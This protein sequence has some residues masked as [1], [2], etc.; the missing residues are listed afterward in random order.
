MIVSILWELNLVVN[1]AGARAALEQRVKGLQL[2]SVILLHHGWSKGGLRARS[3]SPWPL[4]NRHL[5]GDQARA[6]IRGRALGLNLTLTSAIMSC[7]V[8][9]LLGFFV[10][11]EGVGGSILGHSG[12]KYSQSST[13]LLFLA[14]L[15]LKTPRS[16]A[17]ARQRFSSHLA[18][19]LGAFL[20]PQR[21]GARLCATVPSASKCAKASRTPSS[22]A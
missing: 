19:P 4:P 13:G 9:F 17:S 5:G 3:R 10:I 14:V 8:S 21:I 11:G 6:F 1:L 20:C 22:R 15:T 12:M 16:M 7:F 2:L 18:I